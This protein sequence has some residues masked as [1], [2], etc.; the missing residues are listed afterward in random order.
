MAEKLHFRLLGSMMLIAE[1]GPPRPIGSARLQGLIGFLVLTGEVTHDRRALALRLW[2]D[3]REDQAL[4]NLRTLFTRLRRTHPR[5]W[6][7]I[8]IDRKTVGWREGVCI[9]TDLDVLESLKVDEL[10]VENIRAALLES[11][12]ELFLELEDRW[13]LAARARQLALQLRLLDGGLRQLEA[14]GDKEE[15]IAWGQRRLSLTPGHVPTRMTLARLGVAL[16]P[17]P[18][19]ALASSAVGPQDSSEPGGDTRDS[20]AETH[21]Q[22]VGPAGGGSIPVLIGREKPLAE[23]Q[24]LW[25][26]AQGGKWCLATITADSGMGKTRLTEHFEALLRQEGVQTHRL[27]CSNATYSGLLS[28]IITVLRGLSLSHLDSTHLRE[29]SRLLPELMEHHSDLKRPTLMK[30]PWQR[31]RLLEAITQALVASGPTLL[32]IE[33]LQWSDPELLGWIEML[34]EAPPQPQLMVLMTMRPEVDAAD[35]RVSI[36]LKRPQL[37]VPRVPIRLKRLDA[38]ETRLLAKNLATAPLTVKVAKS[39]RKRTGGIPLYVVE[40]LK[41][42][43]SDSPLSATILSE[44]EHAA[45]FLQRFARLLPATRKVVESTAILGNLARRRTLRLATRLDDEVFL[46]GLEQARDAEILVESRPGWW[47]MGHHSF[48]E[49]VLSRLSQDRRVELHRNAA[50]AL[51]ALPPIERV[52][53]KGRVARHYEQGHM[54]EEAAIH[55]LEAVDNAMKLLAYEEAVGLCQQAF[56]AAEQEGLAQLQWRALE[57]ECGAYTAGGRL[58]DAQ[59]TLLQQ[60][61]L[62]A[63][64]EWLHRLTL[65]Y[66]R[67]SVMSWRMGN[68]ET[69]V[70]WSDKA[71]ET[72]EQLGDLEFQAFAEHAHCVAQ[73]QL[74]RPLKELLAN[75]ESAVALS[76]Q[77]R[78]PLLEC[79]TLSQQAYGLIRAKR[80]SQANQVATEALR[81]AKQVGAQHL[82][83]KVR[84]HR[85]LI[86]R[87]LRLYD[88]AEV[89]LQ[90]ALACAADMEDPSCEALVI[91]LLGCL[92]LER[93]RF[94]PAMTSLSC[95][96]KVAIDVEDDLRLQG[97]LVALCTAALNL[98]DLV[99]AGRYLAQVTRVGE[100]LDGAGLVSIGTLRAH[101]QLA[102]GEPRR[103]LETVNRLRDGDAPGTA[104]R[105][106]SIRLTLAGRAQLALGA[107]EKARGLFEQA[108]RH[109]IEALE[110]PPFVCAFE[111]RLGLAQTQL[112]MGNAEATVKT[113]TPVVAWVG[114]CA[115]GLIAPQRAHL[116]L[117]DALLAIGDTKEARAV[118]ALGHTLMMEAASSLTDAAAQKTYLTGLAYNAALQD[119]AREAGR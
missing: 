83:L 119:R 72:A 66:C 70:R 36:T 55:Y 57:A 82:E 117:H 109:R 90:R 63:Q 106:M 24:S 94:D 17:S 110:P 69:G 3:S 102:S 61:T 95:A 39:V 22:P 54:L 15:A 18:E 51:D 64:E 32:I 37:A 62:A 20:Q 9:E 19:D 12:G 34:A 14:A 100:G 13:V 52:I 86:D 91:D 35:H 42:H 11:Q 105:Q 111:A 38:T 73:S 31:R 4:T 50:R 60:E 101:L 40:L 5:I 104:D 116:T 46:S 80:W 41:S 89:K 71:R 96:M 112:A 87:E 58:Q 25:K 75:Q 107:L 26:Q 97:I 103:A 29:L 67:Q 77:V 6:R 2:P 56:A 28:P 45:I 43:A 113:L 108:Y 33:D 59:R 10:S 85:A 44:A 27:R 115:D 118:L 30:R 76:R 88:D 48:G 23:L 93:R 47:M 98:G 99:L 92:E 1:E 7:F 81:R 16:T 21:L 65:V 68:R 74:G 49:A 8:Q 114:G 53:Q 79:E 84:V 78:N